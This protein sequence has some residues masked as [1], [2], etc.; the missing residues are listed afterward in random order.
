MLLDD[1]NE[2]PELKIEKIAVKPEMLSVNRATQRLKKIRHPANA[3]TLKASAFH[4]AF[5]KMSREM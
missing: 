1:L 5:G 2:L 4:V 3:K